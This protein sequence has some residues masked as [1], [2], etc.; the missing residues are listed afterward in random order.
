MVHLSS[1]RREATQATWSLKEC[2]FACH[3]NRLTR[4]H[5][6]VHQ[7]LWT[8]TNF[9]DGISV[10]ISM[11]QLRWIAIAQD[12][13]GWSS[14]IKDFAYACKFLLFLFLN[15]VPANQIASKEASLQHISPALH[16]L[17]SRP[18][19]TLR[20]SMGRACALCMGA[21][22]STDNCGCFSDPGVNVHALSIS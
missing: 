20:S 2:L 19:E 18:W 8:L 16:V 5:H 12:R 22:G 7:W 15:D 10:V 14:L 6:Q 17:L 13:Q 21:V 4:P 1:R 3:D 9:F 11:L